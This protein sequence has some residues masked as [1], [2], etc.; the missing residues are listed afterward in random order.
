MTQSGNA[1]DA[2]SLPSLSVRL[3]KKRAVRAR[4]DALNA[5]MLARAFG[6]EL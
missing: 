6:G 3:T 4:L 1:D 5:A 2:Q